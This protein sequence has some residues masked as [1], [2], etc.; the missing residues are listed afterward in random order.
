MDEVIV[1]KQRK[2]LADKEQRAVDKATPSIEPLDLQSARKILEAP[3][4]NVRRPK[5]RFDPYA[6]LATGPPSVKKRKKTKGLQ[7]SFRG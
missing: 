1:L 6:T 5:K 2:T 3:S 7:K 4:N